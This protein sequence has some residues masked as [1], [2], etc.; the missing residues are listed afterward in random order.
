MSLRDTGVD[1]IPDEILIE[2]FRFSLQPT[3]R[4]DIYMYPVSTNIRLVCHRWNDILLSCPQLWSQIVADPCT[5][6]H[7][8]PRLAIIEKWLQRSSQT[9]ITITFRYP[10]HFPG[11]QDDY[12]TPK[13]NQYFLD[14]FALL[15]HHLVR[16]KSLTLRCNLRLFL[17]A[18]PPS[19]HEAPQLVHLDLMSGGGDKDT[20]ELFSTLN[21]AK[22]LRS[23]RLDLTS[24]PSRTS[25]NLIPLS[26]V[27][28][29]LTHFDIQARL[30]LNLMIGIMRNCVSVVH[31]ALRTLSGHR[32]D[33]ELVSPCPRFQLPHLQTL[34]V[35][36]EYGILDCRFFSY[37]DLPSLQALCIIG[38]G[39]IG[40][41]PPL[42]SFL[43]ASPAS[44]QFVYIKC[45][46]PSEQIPTLF[47]IPRLYNLPIFELCSRCISCR[48]RDIALE[49]SQ[50]VG[51]GKRE[52]VVVKEQGGLPDSLT[53]IGWVSDVAYQQWRG[54]L[55]E[56]GVDLVIRGDLS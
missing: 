21:T 18:L 8:Y 26:P 17:S 44:L 55:C 32:W 30:T 28:H 49:S 4:F 13:E 52:V 35:E 20:I 19:F 33:R 7:I 27:L 2:I 50:V 6:R 41:T 22:S 9:L 51:Q 10:G 37:A 54:A 24:R 31:L 23:L 38:S 11:F 47:S 56:W 39:K 15:K 34:I 53:G 40:N 14:F 36:F 25:L 12:E 5:H 43:E 1:E 48:S 45:N 42:L 29:N 16:W 3:P 46:N